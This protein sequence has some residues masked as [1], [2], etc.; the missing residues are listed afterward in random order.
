M[1]EGDNE[2]RIQR[3]NTQTNITRKIQLEKNKIKQQFGEFNGKMLNSHQRLEDMSSKKQFVQ[4][5]EQDYYEHILET[6]QDENLK[7][8]I[9]TEE[10]AE[11]DW[12]VI[13]WPTTKVFKQRLAVA[14]RESKWSSREERA[15]STAKKTFKNADV[16]TVREKEAMTNYVTNFVNGGD[17]P[18]EGEDIAGDPSL[19]EY[20][21]SIN[22]FEINE[23]IL[24]DDYMSKH[25]AE[26]FELKRKL[27][28]FGD[29]QNQYPIF[30]ASLSDEAKMKLNFRVNLAEDLGNV[31][32]THLKLHGVNVD[33]E[34]GTV[35]LMTESEN[36][37]VREARRTERKTNF[38]TA[39]NSFF[40]KYI[41][42]EQVNIAKSYTEDKVSDSHK[43][44]E[45]IVIQTEEDEAYNELFGNELTIAMD[46]IQKAYNVRNEL[47]AKQ[48]EYLEQLRRA[49]GDMKKGTLKNNIMRLNRRIQIVNQ[50]AGYYR[51]FI[52]LVT[53]KRATVSKQTADFLNGEG[54]KD[55]M[56]IISFKALGDCVEET[57]VANERVKAL[58]R[59]EELRKDHS[60]EANEERQKLENDLA[61]NLT[62]VKMPA[63]AFIAK[64]REY[65]QAK[66]DAAQI[67]EYMKMAKQNRDEVFEKARE[68][69]EEYN[70][71]PNAPVLQKHT[72]R[73]S[74]SI[75]DPLK[76]WK[77]LENFTMVMQ[78][79]PTEHTPEEFRKK[80]IEEN[81][82]PLLKE[83]LAMTPANIEKLRLPENPDIK[84]E[85]YWKNR[86][87]VY[88]GMDMNTYLDNLR[89]WGV[90]LTEEQV[91]QLKT[92]GKV[93]EGMVTNYEKYDI[94]LE[95]PHS[96]LVKG[97]QKLY[98]VAEELS[99]NVL[100]NWNDHVP[101]TGEVEI[102][103]QQ[104]RDCGIEIDT[105][106]VRNPKHKEEKVPEYLDFLVG[107]VQTQKMAALGADEDINTLFERHKKV[108]Q[109][110]VAK[111]RTVQDPLK[112]LMPAEYGELQEKARI[113]LKL[114]AK[115]LDNRVSANDPGFW[116][117]RYGKDEKS[118]KLFKS[119]KKVLRRIEYDAN[120]AP[121]DE[122]RAAWYQNKRDIDDMLSGDEKVRNQAL[123]RIGK[124]MAE[125]TFSEEMLDDKVLFGF[126]NEK[127]WELRE[128]LSRLQGFMELYKEYESVFEGEGLTAQEKEKLHLNITGN[129]VLSKL[130]KCLDLITPTVGAYSDG[131]DIEIPAEHKTAEAKKEYLRNFMTDKLN[132]GKKVFNEEVKSAAQ[133][134]KT[135]TGYVTDK[136]GEYD[137]LNLFL[138]KLDIENQKELDRINA[139]KDAKEKNKAV[140]A[141][142]TKYANYLTCS[143]NLK[144]FIKTL[145]SSLL[146]DEAKVFASQNGIE[147]FTPEEIEQA[148]FNLEKRDMTENFI[149]TNDEDVRTRV[150]IKRSFN[151]TDDAL[152][153]EQMRAWRK[154]YG[155]S[156]IIDVRSFLLL[157]EPVKK[158]IFGNVLPGYEEA[159]EQNQWLY[160]NFMT[161]EPKKMQN[162][163]YQIAQKVLKLEFT[164]EQITAE[165]FAAHKE[166]VILKHVTR[167]AFM[168]FYATY[169]DFFESDVFTEEERDKLRL[170]MDDCG[171]LDA[172]TMLVNQNIIRLGVQD[173]SDANPP[174]DG[175]DIPRWA[176][177]MK[178]QAEDFLKEVPAMMEAG[179]RVQEKIDEG[180][181][182]HAEKNRKLARL[183][184]GSKGKHRE[185]S[186]KK[187]ALGK[188]NPEEQEKLEA[189]MNEAD[190]YEKLYKEARGMLIGQNKDLSEESRKL[191]GV[192]IGA[193][194]KNDFKDLKTYFAKN[195]E[196]F[197]RLKKQGEIDKKLNKQEVERKKL[198]KGW[199][200]MEKERPAAQRDL[201]IKKKVFRDATM[202][203]VKQYASIEDYIK[204][205]GHKNLDADSLE[206]E[207]E[208]QGFIKKL[209]KVKFGP[210][211]LSDEYLSNHAG[212]ILEMVDNLK[213]FSTMREKYP[214]VL[215][216]ISPERIARLDNI[217][218]RAGEIEAVVS[219]NL[220]C[221]GIMLS[222]VGD[223]FHL[224]MVESH[225][226][227]SVQKS[228]N[229]INSENYNRLAT[230]L[231]QKIKDE[232]NQG[233]AEAYTKDKAYSEKSIDLKEL[234]GK[235]K[236]NELTGKTYVSEFGDL[237]ARLELAIQN[238]TK[239]LA[240]QRRLVKNYNNSK[241]EQNNAAIKEQ[242][243]KVLD[244][245]NTVKRYM[246]FFE[247]A[248][249][250]RNTIS[251]ET[252][253]F[254][255]KGE[256][257][258]LYV[259]VITDKIAENAP[260]EAQ[261]WEKVNSIAREDDEIIL[262]EGNI[263]GEDNKVENRLNA[264]NIDLVNEHLNNIKNDGENE[265]KH[266]EIHTEI[267]ENEKH[268][269]ENE[270]GNGNA[271]LIHEDAF[272]NRESHRERND[273]GNNGGNGGETEFEVD[274]RIYITL[275]D[276]DLLETLA[277]E[278]KEY[279]PQ[280]Y[281][282]EKRKEYLKFLSDNKHK[283]PKNEEELVMI[284]QSLQVMKT[285]ELDGRQRQDYFYKKGT[286]VKLKEAYNWL[287][288]Y[289]RSRQAHDDRFASRVIKKVDIP[290]EKVEVEYKGKYELQG[291]NNCW[292]CTGAAIYN[293]FVQ[294]TY[295]KKE[296]PMTQY[297]VRNFVPKYREYDEIQNDQ[298]PVDKQ[299]YDEMR[300]SE[301][302][303]FG[304]GKVAVGSVFEA[305]DLFL[306]KHKDMM[307]NRM[308]FYTPDNYYKVARSKEAKKN[309][310]VIKNNQK[311]MFVT[312]VSKV[313]K[314]GNLVGLLTYDEKGLKHYRT[315]KGINGEMVKVMDSLQN[316][317][318][319][320][321]LDVILGSANGRSIEI[322]W[323]EKLKKPEEMKK[324]F[325]NLEY[326]EKEGYSQKEI[327]QEA[328][329][330]VAQRDGVCVGKLLDSNMRFMDWAAYIPKH[331]AVV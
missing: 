180:Y 154:K 323:F 281:T 193:K 41:N 43:A 210:D 218:K 78:Y 185:L 122:Y 286:D 77:N 171:T 224:D 104:Y 257:S 134:Q 305:G 237:R 33:L 80:M 58:N 188:S 308:T 320:T 29:L 206:N 162:T 153:S 93:T 223:Q 241:T 327:T 101:P 112:D 63:D 110:D 163:L 107:Q 5:G 131:K 275:E 142:S 199:E 266:D 215:K 73:I 117:A 249:G 226:S 219:A 208:V 164:P 222:R 192:L 198:I 234:D 37:S 72:D 186:L 16:C 30:F 227:T 230:T 194:K 294:N 316:N 240:N 195:K 45:A 256:L 126:G 303:F 47:I 98:D 44:M 165:Y 229:R 239:E 238:R 321:S 169:R 22:D 79:A 133:A 141:Y 288:G 87:L 50:H 220:L 326:S 151:K 211:S 109:K 125:F 49:Q 121:K 84:S 53:G 59:I 170:T 66:S 228:L 65:R 106:H 12:A 99:P 140:E 102:A 325:S 279:R 301:E 152:S 167:F 166:E 233:V 137:K 176:R 264:E 253:A 54:R 213:E 273:G 8:K 9:K 250:E 197:E 232:E 263:H 328:L 120:G 28:M 293:Q 90:Q 51:E 175:L 13:N 236:A 283:V 304:K 247:F 282:E 248:L 187:S 269:N 201:E 189:Q 178:K 94:L 184:A 149:Y 259:S 242:N 7:L 113:R 319:E 145:D 280:D 70:K 313:L 190:K 138:E 88:I 291:G 225:K 311:A 135:R 143:E 24:T 81:L 244:S 285:Y 235:I 17:Q 57:I 160:D 204:A 173:G 34:E 147:L 144:I 71:D 82:M 274:G 25:I 27:D 4:V 278:T 183:A 271:N 265:E 74:M 296:A 177:Q 83:L 103:F 202:A 129:P 18:V 277:S 299:R 292:A 21:R 114:N 67:K 302:A 62:F 324:E 116:E 260:D 287:M 1:A 55:M 42:D 221:H 56:E 139:I 289:Y 123:I 23:E 276:P 172:Q 329:D 157:L 105:E 85:E 168:N 312:Q 91:V 243:K 61:N 11:G 3:T 181:F 270:T 196:E 26:L 314:A 251:A 258:S 136:R 246:E 92:Y 2:V 231:S 331:P 254:M 307:M 46:E 20:V 97:N 267:N 39:R 300:A 68:Q 295:K 317:E 124:E 40:N 298:I 161:G 96:V 52:D 146:T 207:A 191:L 15:I 255:L 297:T 69:A 38:E 272:R 76:K 100:Q 216:N 128:Q 14:T 310:A 330:N 309:D 150:M 155:S 209:E 262:E 75:S 200:V 108:M 205:G 252:S 245:I 306:N 290:Q 130:F 36:K 86:S 156:G 89:S 95:D 19:M 158:D 214:E 127:H 115:E 6:S 217:A 64:Y 212:E 318:Y 174:E 322:T 31:I 159:D 315:I 182:F 203:T 268:E 35:T 179:N 148:E 10:V 284:R 118:K 48:K 32:D 132:Q 119:F 60:P 111:Y 261:G